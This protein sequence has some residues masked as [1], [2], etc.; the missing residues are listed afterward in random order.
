MR[1][2]KYQLPI[3]TQRSPNNKQLFVNR[4]KIQSQSGKG[5]PTSLPITG[6]LHKQSLRLLSA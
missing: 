4:S 5:G 3:I 2:N 6:I 1:I